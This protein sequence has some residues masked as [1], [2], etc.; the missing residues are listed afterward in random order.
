MRATQV[1]KSLVLV[2]VAS[3]CVSPKPEVHTSAPDGFYTQANGPKSAYTIEVV[4]R[5]KTEVFALLPCSSFTPL[6]AI[7]FDGAEGWYVQ[8]DG[9]VVGGN[10]SEQTIVLV[11]NHKPYLELSKG[12]QAV[13]SDGQRVGPQAMISLVLPTRSEA[14]SIVAAMRNRYPLL[15]MVQPGTAG[16]SRPQ[17]D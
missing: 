7:V 5:G 9:R 8:I 10:W 12:G 17:P 3:G 6:R 15:T 1:L 2:L 4:S 13:G 11:A 14:E 16:S